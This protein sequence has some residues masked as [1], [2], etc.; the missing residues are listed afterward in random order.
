MHTQDI[1]QP[2]RNVPVPS[3]GS[4]QCAPTLHDLFKGQASES[5]SPGQAI[6]WEGDQAG[7]IFDVLEG[8]LRVYRIL[9]DGRRAIMGF[10]HAG[11]ML[12]VSFQSR[13]LFTA[14][15]IDDVKVRRFPRQRFFAL[16]NDS[17]ELRPQLFAMLCD[18]ATAAQDQMLLLGRKSAEERVVS[19]LLAVHRK[20]GVDNTIEL[21]MSRLDMADYLGLTIETVSRMMT[22]L[23]RKGL[24]ASAGRHSIT[25]RRLGALRQAAGSDE[26][27]Q[28]PRETAPSR[29]AVWPN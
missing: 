20:A 17:P 22:G 4:I 28:D 1:V 24:I 2:L 21:P 29:R 23:T 14:E 15:A 5:Y 3:N 13:Y 10:I 27:D 8:V 7:H 19:F 11:E 25:L 12:G 9:P 6:F 18:E 16:V 26:E